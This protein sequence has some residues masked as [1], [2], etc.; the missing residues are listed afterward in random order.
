MPEPLGIFNGVNSHEKFSLRLKI[1]PDNQ[2]LVGAWESPNWCLL[3]GQV[4][5]DKS[6]LNRF[7]AETNLSFLLIHEVTLLLKPNNKKNNFMFDLIPESCM[8][9]EAFDDNRRSYSSPKEL[10]RSTAFNL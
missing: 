4:E 5:I 2:F 9:S 1:L 7:G 3:K 6:S 8:V 10:I